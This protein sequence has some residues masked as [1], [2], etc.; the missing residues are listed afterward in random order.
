MD[1]IQLE[2]FKQDVETVARRLIGVSLLIDG[3]GGWIV[4]TEAYDALDPAAHSYRGRTARNAAVFGPPGHAYV[5]RSY[6]IHWCLNVVCGTEVGGAV[7]IR[8]IEPSAGVAAMIARRG[9]DDLRGLCSGPGRL[10]QALGIDGSFD[11]RALD[12]PPFELSGSAL[13]TIQVGPRIGLS[14]G[15]EKLWRFWLEGSRFVSRPV[16]GLRKTKSVS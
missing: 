2:F 3:V 7:L 16:P 13:T 5:N 1:R 9:I 10:C 11:G 6:G 4:E 15:K 12:R 14:R 8:A